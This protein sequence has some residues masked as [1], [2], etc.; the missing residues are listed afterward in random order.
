MNGKCFSLV[1]SGKGSLRVMSRLRPDLKF[2]RSRA[3]SHSLLFQQ[4]RSTHRQPVP[5]SRTTEAYLSSIRRHFW[6]SCRST[7]RQYERFHFKMEIP[8]TCVAVRSGAK[9]RR[10][11]AAD[12]T[13]SNSSEFEVEES[14]MKFNSHS[15]Y[16]IFNIFTI[17]G[18]LDRKLQMNLYIEEK[19]RGKRKGEEERQAEEGEAREFKPLSE[20]S[21]VRKALPLLAAHCCSLLLRVLCARRNVSETAENTESEHFVLPFTG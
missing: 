7:V 16:F 15:R 19:Q 4:Y 3:I 11:G 20:C 1:F 12:A 2:I 17:F 14:T 21:L 6:L 13:K 9:N 10:R 8:Q 5:V 18:S